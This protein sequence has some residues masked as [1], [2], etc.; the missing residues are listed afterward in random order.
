[1]VKI[2]LLQDYLLKSTYDPAAVVKENSLWL[3]IE[4]DVVSVRR[5]PFHMVWM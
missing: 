3:K 1:V 5:S 4:H 2:R